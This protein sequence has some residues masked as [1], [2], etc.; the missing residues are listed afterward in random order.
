MPQWSEFLDFNLLRPSTFERRHQQRR[1]GHRPTVSTISLPNTLPSRQSTY[2]APPAPGHPS[3]G[4]LGFYSRRRQ[5][6][7]DVR[8]RP[9]IADISPPS[10]SSTTAP[11][12]QA[13]GDRHNRSPSPQSRSTSRPRPVSTATS[14]PATTTPSSGFGLFASRLRSFHS[15][16]NTGNTNHARGGSIEIPRRLSFSSSTPN[17]T[18]SVTPSRRPYFFRGSSWSGHG[19]HPRQNS[20]GPTSL[21]T[22]PVTDVPP[23]LLARPTTGLDMTPRM[24]RV[25]RVSVEE[26]QPVTRRDDGDIYPYTYDVAIT[27]PPLALTQATSMSTIQS[28]SSDGEVSR[29]GSRAHTPTTATLPRGSMSDSRNNESGVLFLQ[30]PPTA[31]QRRILA[32]RAYL[33]KFM[34]IVATMPVIA[35][36]AVYNKIEVVMWW[37]IAVPL[38][39]IAVALIWR[40]KLGQRLQRL[41][42]EISQLS[43]PMDRGSAT[44][45][46][47][48]RNPEEEGEI[49][50]PPDYHASI[51]TPPAYLVVP[52]KVPS[53]RSLENLFAFARTMGQRV[54]QAATVAAANTNDATQDAATVSQP[55]SG[56][57]MMPV[58][59]ATVGALPEM[60]EVGPGFSECTL[61]VLDT[62]SPEGDLDAQQLPGESIEDME[63]L[64]VA[65]TRGMEAS[66]EQGSDVA[67]FDTSTVMASGSSSSPD[68]ADSTMASHSF[69]KDLKGKAPSRE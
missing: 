61:Q 12:I 41:D 27:I 69:Q 64:A 36:L 46:T 44:Q 23:F 32:Q 19:H 31:E 47:R 10:S 30:R 68:T 60:R 16:S 22:P 8:P 43:L 25:R 45:E 5:H 3:L 52:R 54:V 55:Q 14:N 15:S 21:P 29:G 20:Q 65:T 62:I 37:V 11:V 56:E 2:T 4:Y 66:H 7:L 50:P 67:V 49:S 58:A 34:C 13:P 33:K 57:M 39:G 42:E 28:V 38:V 17:D 18:T 48:T 6:S 40:R 35:T 24:G 59:R 51:I 53:Y 1:Y 26:D 9:V 63:G